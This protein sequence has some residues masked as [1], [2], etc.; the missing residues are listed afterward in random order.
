MKERGMGNGTHV[1]SSR[2]LD[3]SYC[4]NVVSRRHDRNVAL[5]LHASRRVHLARL[6][7]LLGTYIHI[8]VLGIHGRFVCRLQLLDRIQNGTPVLIQLQTS[9]TIEKQPESN[10]SGCFLLFGFMTNRIG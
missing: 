9:D 4:T 1:S 2:L 8:D 7:E 6:S 10:D 5:V 3:V